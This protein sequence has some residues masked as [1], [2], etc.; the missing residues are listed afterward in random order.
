ML[1]L[2]KMINKIKNKLDLKHYCNRCKYHILY[3]KEFDGHK[4][5]SEAPID[6]GR[7]ICKLS[8]QIIKN[9]IGVKIFKTYHELERCPTCSQI[10]HDDRE[11]R[12][13]KCAK[14]NYKLKCKFFKAR[15]FLRL[16]M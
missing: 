15:W 13:E 14:K 9:D 5:N 11:I 12:Y 16:L 6:D 2:T 7:H 8:F 10:T 4:R 3:M 1:I